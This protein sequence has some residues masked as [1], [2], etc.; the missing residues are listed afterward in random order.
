MSKKTLDFSKICDIEV[1]GIDFR[2]YPDFCDA[3]IC[4]GIYND[5]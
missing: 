1:D 2:D 4:E 5:G 3:F